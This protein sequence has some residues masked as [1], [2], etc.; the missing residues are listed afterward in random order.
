MYISANF[1]NWHFKQNILLKMIVLGNEASPPKNAA[2]IWI[3]SKTEKVV[4][5]RLVGQIQILKT[6]GGK[7]GFCPTFSWS[8]EAW[9]IVL[10]EFYRE[11]WFPPCFP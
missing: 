4:K 9:F 2:L 10:K 8:N 1:S 5:T 7:K 6:F 3:S 11:A